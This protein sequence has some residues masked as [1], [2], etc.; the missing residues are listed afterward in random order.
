MKKIS[1]LG[2]STVFMLCFACQKAPDRN[3]QNEPLTKPQGNPPVTAELSSYNTSCTDISKR[4]TTKNGETVRNES[5][6]LIEGTTKE[7]EIS[8]STTKTEEKFK[9]TFTNY[10]VEGADQKTQTSKTVMTEESVSE[11]TVQQVELNIT[12]TTDKMTGK[13]TVLEGPPFA[14]PDGSTS[15]TENFTE[16]WQQ[17]VYND[18][19][20]F[21]V[22]E[23]K[24]DGKLTGSTVGRYRL[25]KSSEQE[26]RIQVR[27]RT[28]IEPV[29]L[30]EGRTLESKVRTCR[31]EKVAP[32]AP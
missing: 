21:Y 22:I 14:N 27:T 20:I 3:Q 32:T 5:V 2:A 11:S 9:H 12:L 23:T 29:S 18:G 7:I 17:K 16:E 19:E 6:L 15:T 1:L 25:T 30:G 31:T 8:E 10:K 24:L 26:G 4:T 13:R 28:L